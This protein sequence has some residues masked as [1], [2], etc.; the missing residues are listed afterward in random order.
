[1]VP[2]IFLHGPPATGKYTIGREL[3]AR[4][5]LEL[6]HNHLV[7]DA[8]LARH[9]FGSPEFVAERDRLWRERLE[10]VGRD[11]ARGVIFTFNPE[12]SVPQA[13]IDWLFAALPRANAVALHSVAVTASEAVIESRLASAQ[14]QGF[15]KLTDLALYRQLRA[16]GVFD[17]PRIPRSDLTIDSEQLT[18]AMAAEQIARTFALA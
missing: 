11:G 4:T 13:F 15:R 12:N 14:R 10:V 16:A 18:P 1:M 7:V 3:A 6:F 5:G 8:V 2:L 17:S 9:A